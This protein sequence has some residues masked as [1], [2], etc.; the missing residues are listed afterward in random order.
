M[1]GPR[2]LSNTDIPSLLL[3]VAVKTA[4]KLAVVATITIIMGANLPLVAGVFA[5]LLVVDSAIT[6]GM[7]LLKKGDVVR[8]DTAR[9]LSGALKVVLATSFCFRVIA[10][11][12]MPQPL[13]ICLGVFLGATAISDHYNL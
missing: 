11:C 12:I 1:I 10:L 2:A 5:S 4:I 3:D 9:Y 6:V 7:V 13:T 8:P